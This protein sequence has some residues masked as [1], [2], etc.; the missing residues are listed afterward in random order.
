MG[1]IIYKY[2]NFKDEKF[3]AVSKL[4]Y[5][6]LFKPYNKIEKYEYDEFD[7][8]SLHLVAIDKDNVAGYSRMTNIKGRGKITNV[9]VCV[10]YIN[11]RIG[12]EM[13]KT[14]I[15]RAKDDNMSYIYLNSRLD[16]VNFYKKS[17]FQCEGEIMISKRSGLEL[18]KMYMNL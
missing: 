7:D 16:T 18:Q 1:D 17:G 15:C 10:E 11:K 12:F 5:D 3:K 6:I 13:M 4:R 8:I 9:F 14:H 2:I